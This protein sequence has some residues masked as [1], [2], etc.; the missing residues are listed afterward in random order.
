MAVSKQPLSVGA[1]AQFFN[2]ATGK[3]EK[4]IVTEL[5]AES[6][7]FRKRDIKGRP[8]GPTRETSLEFIG[9][10]KRDVL[11]AAREFF[12]QLASK[13]KSTLK[14]A[15]KA[16]KAAKQEARF[17]KKAQTMFLQVE[18]TEKALEKREAAKAAKPKVV[19][20]GA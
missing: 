5:G 8:N 17:V 13:S 7:K 2:I 16:I 3:F 10:A 18:R 19:E 6:I 9:R 15:A 20:L 14:E 4:V 1:K 12:A 11:P